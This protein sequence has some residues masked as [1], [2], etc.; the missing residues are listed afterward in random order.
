MKILLVNK[1]LHPNGGSETYIFKIGSYLVQNG[2]EVQYFGMEHEGRIVGNRVKEYT[3]DMDFRHNGLMRFFY[4]FK[5]LYS[6]EAKKKILKVLEDFQPDVVHINNFNFQLTPSILYGIKEYSKRI[7]KKIPIIF[8]AHDYQLICP[9]HMLLRGTD[10]KLCERCIHGSFYHCTMG[11]C[12]HGSTIKSLLGSI[13][14]YLY[15]NLKTYRFFD[16]IICPSEFLEKK[17]IENPVFREKTV[18]LHNFRTTDLS[19]YKEMVEGAYV[20][21]FGRYSEE[22]GILTLIEAC[23]RLPDI[24]FVFA[25]NGPMEDSMNQVSNIANVGFKT[26][27]DLKELIQN[28]AFAIIASE[29]YENCPFSVMEAQSYGTPVLGAAIGGIPELIE[30]KRTG[31]LFESGNIAD[32]TEHISTLWNNPEVTRKYRKNCK[33]ITY[34]TVGQYCDKLIEIYQQVN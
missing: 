16:K 7:A 2:H 18:A 4:P 25:G 14:G 24:P 20:L 31:E 11:K 22:K 15:R 21:Y 1:F 23:K 19:E 26:G 34:D 8:T 3:A 13:E 17:M 12:I 30:D 29:W 27:D 28:A 9:N 10:N 6:R 32:L 33:D 5:I